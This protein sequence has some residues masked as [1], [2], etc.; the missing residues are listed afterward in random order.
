MHCA[1]YIKQWA[2]TRGFL[3]ARSGGI[4]SLGYVVM[5][6]HVWQQ[7]HPSPSS[8]PPSHSTPLSNSDIPRACLLL[9]H[10]FSFVPQHLKASPRSAYCFAVAPPPSAHHNG[11]TDL[12]HPPPPHD[13]RRFT[14]TFPDPEHR[15]LGKT[16][17]VQ[18][19]FLPLVNLGRYSPSPC[20]P[21]PLPS[22]PPYV[23]FVSRAAAD[24]LLAA[25]RA[26]L[27]DLQRGSCTP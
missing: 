27:A 17:Y 4:P 23:R 10:F 13:V 9:L 25:M 16:V 11:S 3:G 26:T 7:L 15:G 18:D 22:S 20:H 21:P 6:L 1:R 8:P 14:G 12:H 24:A 5:L 19:P 2:L